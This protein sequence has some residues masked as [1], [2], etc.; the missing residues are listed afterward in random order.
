MNTQCCSLSHQYAK[1]SL[2]QKKK[3]KQVKSPNVQIYIHM[4]PTIGEWRA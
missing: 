3:K 4:S 2:V 1:I